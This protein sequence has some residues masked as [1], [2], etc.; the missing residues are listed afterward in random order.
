VKLR[1]EI[2]RRRITGIE[3]WF[4]NEEECDERGKNLFVLTK[5]DP[6]MDLIHGLPEN[7][8]CQWHAEVRC[9]FHHSWSFFFF[10]L[11]FDS[12]SEPNWFCFALLRELRWERKVN[13]ETDS[14]GLE[15]T[16][17]QTRP[18]I[19]AFGTAICTVIFYLLT[20][21]IFWKSY[22][23]SLPFL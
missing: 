7:E 4:E 21:T 10:F 1:I 18:I 14:I 12:V 9:N 6:D 13:C 16:R 22:F 23:H 15:N 20:L 2:E 5:S 8:S 11:C 19:L 3:F 17:L